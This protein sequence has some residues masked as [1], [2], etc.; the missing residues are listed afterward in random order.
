[1]GRCELAWDLGLGS[2]TKARWVSVGR[3]HGAGTWAGEEWRKK[4]KKMKGRRVPVAWIDGEWRK[5]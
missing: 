4:E 5:R 1:M 2:A 3:R